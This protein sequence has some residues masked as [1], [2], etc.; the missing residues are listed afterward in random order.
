MFNFLLCLKS[1]H[2]Q[3]FGRIWSG[4]DF[5]YQLI[6]SNNQELGFKPPTS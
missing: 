2:K 5:A 4:H 6:V 1:R 3:K